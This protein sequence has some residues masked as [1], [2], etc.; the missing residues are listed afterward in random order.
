MHNYRLQRALVYVTSDAAH[1]QNPRTIMVELVN[2]IGMTLHNDVRQLE[3]IILECIS[4]KIT[5]LPVIRCTSA[6]VPEQLLVRVLE[7]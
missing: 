3:K 6:Q 5:G 4:L 2:H 7:T 1:V